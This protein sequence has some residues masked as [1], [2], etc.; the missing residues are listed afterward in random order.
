MNAVVPGHLYNLEN[1]DPGEAGSPTVQTLAFIRKESV[2]GVFKTVANGT[3]NEEVLRALIDRLQF[4]QAKATCRENALA[5]T[6][7]EE[8]LMWLERRTAD[9][10]ARGVEGTDRK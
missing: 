5:I 2:D 3:T 6:K 7:L 10:K 8:A 9:R 4:L 1:A